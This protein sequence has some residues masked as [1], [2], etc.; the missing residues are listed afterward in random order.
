MRTANK[1]IILLVAVLVVTGCDWLR[2][3][4]GMATSQELEELKMESVRE[5][6]AQRVRDS[7]DKVVA[8]SLAMVAD[9]L[10]AEQASQV[11]SLDETKRF[12]VILGSFKVHSNSERMAENLRKKGYEPVVFSFHNGFEAV[13]VC[14]YDRVTPAFNAMYR[15]LDEG[16]GPDDIWVYDVR[17]NLHK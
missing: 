15:L 16:F 14:S 4:L 3:Q 10:E 1:L 11:A 6:A 17:Q 9:S 13:S 2:S 7:L 12:H 5:A 8:D